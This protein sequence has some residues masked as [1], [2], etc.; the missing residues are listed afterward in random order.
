MSH[1]LRT[2]TYVKRCRVCG[3]LKPLN[4]FYRATG[5]R[6]GHRNDCK[7]CNLAAKKARTALDPVANLERV[8]RWQ[9]ENPDR[10]NAYRRAYRQRP[11]RKRAE[12]ESHL[13]RQ[14]GMSLADYERMFERQAGLCRICGVRPRKGTNLHV[15]HDHETGAVRGLLCFKCNNAIGLF[16]ESHDL[17]QAAADY[18][19]RDDELTPL[20]RERARALVA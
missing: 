4:D 9:R 7:L 1:V 12:R 18:L 20:V 10:L 3:V 5:M 19:K 11:E 13:Q 2:I 16:D 17:F 15:D 8:K 6:D 14:Y